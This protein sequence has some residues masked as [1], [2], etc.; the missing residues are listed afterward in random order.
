MRGIIGSG[1]PAQIRSCPHP[2]AADRGE[3]A[4]SRG[5]RKPMAIW[6]APGGIRVRGVPTLDALQPPTSDVARITVSGQLG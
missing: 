1:C 6:T 5:E 3:R 4:S 2:S